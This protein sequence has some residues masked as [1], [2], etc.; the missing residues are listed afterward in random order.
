MRLTMPAQFEL[1]LKNCDPQSVH[2]IGALAI[3]HLLD[4]DI[5]VVLDIAAESF[6]RN[7]RDVSALLLKKG[8]ERA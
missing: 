7:L 8:F 3:R 5:R 1:L 6:T 4:V 2:I